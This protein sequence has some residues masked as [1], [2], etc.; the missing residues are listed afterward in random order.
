MQTF[1]TKG[2]WVELTNDF[3]IPWKNSI[4]PCAKHLVYYHGKI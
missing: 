4:S 2:V 3:P 1:G